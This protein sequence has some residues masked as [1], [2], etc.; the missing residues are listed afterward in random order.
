MKLTAIFLTPLLSAFNS[1]N[2]GSNYDLPLTSGARELTDVEGVAYA[3]N[4]IDWKGKRVDSL[5]FNLFYPTGA[6]SKQK[7]PLL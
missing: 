5:Q 7:Y 1:L 2:L 4:L 3:K 6:S